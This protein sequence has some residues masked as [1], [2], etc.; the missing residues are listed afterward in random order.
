MDYFTKR[1]IC[2]ACSIEL[3]AMYIYSLTLS[4]LRKIYRCKKCH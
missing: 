1:S 3:N 2:I 4:K